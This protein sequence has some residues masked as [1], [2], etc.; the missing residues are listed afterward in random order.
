MRGVEVVRDPGQH[1]HVNERYHQR[2]AVHGVT[3][4][5]ALLEYGLVR[6]IVPAS[7]HRAV[8]ASYVEVVLRQI[9]MLLVMS[10]AVQLDAVDRVPLASGKRRIV[11]RKISVERVGGLDGLVQ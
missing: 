5:F 11:C 8:Q 1:A 6:L 9:E 2:D 7:V 3:N 4:R 10:H